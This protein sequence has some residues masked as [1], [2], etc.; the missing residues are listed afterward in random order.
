MNTRQTV[1][2]LMRTQ[3][4]HEK[5]ELKGNYIKTS[6][7]AQNFLLNSAFELSSELNHYPLVAS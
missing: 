3:K 2:I 4:T 7:H 1:T 6:R 5:F